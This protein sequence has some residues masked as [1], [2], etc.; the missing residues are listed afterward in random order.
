VIIK[1][2]QEEGGTEK[3][4][5]EHQAI[6]W[7]YIEEYEET[8]W[9]KALRISLTNNQRQRMFIKSI[10][11]FSFFMCYILIFHISQSL[12]VFLCFWNFLWQ[13]NFWLEAL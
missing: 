7:I 9:W 3:E 1:K 6:Y 13:A 5:V 10:Y 12:S 4:G 2:E 11:I 8:L